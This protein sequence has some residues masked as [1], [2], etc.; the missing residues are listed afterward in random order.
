MKI[1]KFN[2]VLSL[3]TTLAIFIHVGYTAYAYL[4]FYYN[5]LLK[6]ITAMPFM[7]F[8]CLHAIC[9]MGIVFFSADGTKL[10]QYPK[11]N[12]GTILQ[13]ASAIHILPLLILHINT[14]DILKTC[15]GNGKWFFFALVMIFQPI[16]Y[17][18]VF[19]HVTVS[20]S[21]AL[22]TLGRLSSLEKKKTV[23]RI[24]LIICAVFFL[25]ASYAVIKGQLTM[26]LPQ[27]G[28]A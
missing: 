23:D 24:V 26:F 22:I 25:V 12:I 16:F 2:A 8:A 20:V 11:K 21:R 14:F 4:T 15:A 5:P 3:L 27:G 28:A 10:G 6:E 7:A 9:A 13:R 1:K 19:T 18:T 17:A